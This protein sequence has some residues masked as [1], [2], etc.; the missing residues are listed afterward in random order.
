MDVRERYRKGKG[1]EKNGM[2]ASSSASGLAVAF[3]IS[4]LAVFVGAVGFFGTVGVSLSA[5]GPSPRQQPQ[6][7]RA[8]GTI[9]HAPSFGPDDRQ[10]D[11]P[12]LSP[13]ERAKRDIDAAFPM[14]SSETITPGGGEYSHATPEDILSHHVTAKPAMLKDVILVRDS[15]VALTARISAVH[16]AL[17]ELGAGDKMIEFYG[18][19]TDRLNEFRFLRSTVTSMQSLVTRLGTASVNDT[20]SRRWKIGGGE[21]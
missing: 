9:F 3:G 5:P 20:F 12:R 15:V 16:D 11:S 1:K 17:R 19:F 18:H 4:A 6:L 8:H 10:S 13:S 2:A 7:G 14:P 21:R